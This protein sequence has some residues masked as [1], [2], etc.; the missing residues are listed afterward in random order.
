VKQ[1]ITSVGLPQN[2]GFRFWLHAAGI[3]ER[4]RFIVK[5]K[6]FPHRQRAG[7]SVTAENINALPT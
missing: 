7:R 5:Q 2:L 1:N 6:A 4:K 3:K